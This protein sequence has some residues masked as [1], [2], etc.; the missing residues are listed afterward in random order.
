[1]WNK[2]FLL[3]KVNISGKVLKENVADC[4][5]LICASCPRMTVSGCSRWGAACRLLG[6]QFAERFATV[7]NCILR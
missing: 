4:P 3:L 2:S 7:Q 1:M 5:D 6:S